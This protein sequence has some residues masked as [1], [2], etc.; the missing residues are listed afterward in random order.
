MTLPIDYYEPFLFSPTSLSMISGLKVAEL[1]HLDSDYVR[2][3]TCKIARL[4][5][6]TYF[7][8][9]CMNVDK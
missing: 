7:C 2:L 3:L 6:R 9:T 1:Y 4:C 5:D 8:L